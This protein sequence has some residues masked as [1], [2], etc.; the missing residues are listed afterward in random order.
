MYGVYCND[1][2]NACSHI[3]L[4]QVVPVFEIWFL[5]W[6]F[7]RAYLLLDYYRI[8]PQKQGVLWAVRDLWS[9]FSPP[10]N[11][12]RGQLQSQGRLLSTFIS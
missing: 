8:W 5:Y 10:P 7:T 3:T 11:S 12:K 1:M 4:L 6:K 9:P 2:V